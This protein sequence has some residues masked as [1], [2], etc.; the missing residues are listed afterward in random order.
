MLKKMM[1]WDPHLKPKKKKDKGE[2]M[3]Y[4]DEFEDDNKE[5]RYRK[6]TD[7]EVGKLSADSKDLKKLMREKSTEKFDDDISDEDEKEFQGVEDLLEKKVKEPKA[8][9]KR[10]PNETQTPPATKKTRGAATPATPADPN[11]VK[12]TKNPPTEKEVE[13]QIREF[14]SVQGKVP[15]NRVLQKF[16]DVISVISTAS[17][18]EILKRLVEAKQENNVTFLYLKDDQYREF[19]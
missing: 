1:V 10:G 6:N 2:D 13:K 7:F 9:E 16:K 5:D 4:E 14:L 18:K 17:F 12:I 8:G 15:L 19:R 3:D 11:A